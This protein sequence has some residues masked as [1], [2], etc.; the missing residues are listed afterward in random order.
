MENA[1]SHI[2]LLSTKLKVTTIAFLPLNTTNVVQPLDQ[3][4]VCCYKVLHRTA[5]LME[6][7][8]QFDVGEADPKTDIG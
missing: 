4:I 1:P 8:L 3:G 7:I 6:L 2:K 5:M